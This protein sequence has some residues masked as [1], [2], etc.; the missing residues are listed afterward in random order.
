M[1]TRTTIDFS[2]IV[3]SRA[4]TLDSWGDLQFATLAQLLYQ[5]R[6]KMDG[7]MPYIAAQRHPVSALRIVSGTSLDSYNDSWQP[8]LTFQ[9]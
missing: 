7:T 4:M 6:S 8:Y 3:L 2:S 1:F 5:G 9:T